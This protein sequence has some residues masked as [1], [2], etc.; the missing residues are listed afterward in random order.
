[1][2]DQIATVGAFASILIDYTIIALVL[3]AG[4]VWRFGVVA[5]GAAWTALAY[6]LGVTGQ[7]A[8]ASQVPLIGVLCAAPVLVVG[9]L[10]W[11]SPGVRRALTGLP[12]PL[13]I[14]LN[15]LR[16]Q[17]GLFLALAAEGRLSGPFPYSAGWG[18]VITGVLS[19]PVAYA[20]LR[21]PAK[22]APFVAL[23]N[24]FGVIDLISA[25]ALGVLSANGSPLQLIHAG[26]GSYAMQF[27]PFSLVPTVLVPFYM[28]S[29]LIIA[30]QLSS[31][32]KTAA[33][34][35]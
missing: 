28:L 14:V 32:R 5:F 6:W 24:L 22:A 11:V 18:D 2:L 3:K 8:F 26:V 21:A 19:V 9:L 27:P 20:A 31:S 4:P 25:V 12:M 15:V 35:A 23:W 7:L 16:V 34:A 33:A 13:L 17:G 10:M 30:I 1:M 29:H